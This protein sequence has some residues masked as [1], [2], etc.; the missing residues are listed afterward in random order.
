LNKACESFTRYGY[1]YNGDYCLKVE[2]A[3]NNDIITKGACDNCAE[4][5]NKPGTGAGTGVTCASQRVAFT[6]PTAQTRPLA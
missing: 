3:E 2:D 1:H 4:C 5:E 6:A